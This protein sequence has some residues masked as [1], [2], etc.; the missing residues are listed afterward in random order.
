[1]PQA[2]FKIAA[3]PTSQLQL[4]SINALIQVGQ[5]REAFIQLQPLVQADPMNAALLEAVSDCYWHMGTTNQAMVVLNTIADIWP[6][7]IIVWGKLGARNMALG[8]KPAAGAAFERMLELEPNSALA[9]TALN[10]IK[11]FAP[12]SEHA[13]KLQ[14]LA[15]D[16]T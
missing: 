5:Y 3:K 7:N 8:D 16:A 10:L 9:L 2:S 14:L 6:D 13:E 15:K 1:M 11:T 4:G 12:D